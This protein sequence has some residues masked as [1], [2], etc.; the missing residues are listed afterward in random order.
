MPPTVAPYPASPSSAT[1]P[2]DQRSTST[3]LIESKYNSLESLNQGLTFGLARILDGLATL[4]SR[5]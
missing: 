1:R 5:R 4:I 2:V 3:R